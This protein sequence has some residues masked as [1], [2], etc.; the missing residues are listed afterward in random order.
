MEFSIETG[1]LAKQIAWPVVPEGFGQSLDDIPNMWKVSYPAGLTYF[2]DQFYPCVV[3]HEYYIEVAASLTK[4]GKKPVSIGD[5][6]LHRED[7]PTAIQL[8]NLAIEKGVTSKLHL[9]HRQACAIELGQLA[10]IN[11]AP[12]LLT[13]AWRDADHYVG[14]ETSV[15]KTGVLTICVS[16]HMIGRW[17]GQKQVNVTLMANS[18]GHP[19]QIADHNGIVAATAYPVCKVQ[20]KKFFTPENPT[21]S[22]KSGFGFVSTPFGDA[23]F[24]KSNVENLLKRDGTLPSTLNAQLYEN[25]GKFNVEFFVEEQ[26]AEIELKQKAQSKAVDVRKAQKEIDRAELDALLTPEFLIQISHMLPFR[27]H[28]QVGDVEVK[29]GFGHKAELIQFDPEEGAVVTYTQFLSFWYKTGIRQRSFAT[30]KVGWETVN[31]G[32]DTFSKYSNKHLPE[33]GTIL[34]RFSLSD[35]KEF[36]HEYPVT[37]TEGESV[38]AETPLCE[39]EAVNKSKEE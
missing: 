32:K 18:F 36:F 23:Y 3:R 5:G 20:V 26:E 9:V 15:S 2:L 14:S 24:N 13:S 38:F 33:N 7:W 4:D 17:I 12:G 6:F 8:V 27:K 35:G 39:V 19:V 30:T 34:V 31:I 21:G 28:M 22:G 29:A 11:M 1:I 25:R 10:Q 37:R 16:D